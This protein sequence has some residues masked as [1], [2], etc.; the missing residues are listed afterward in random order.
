M[1]IMFH[2]STLLP[3][4]SLDPQQIHRKRRIGNDIGVV[5]FQDGGSFKP[6]ISSELIR[7]TCENLTIIIDAYFVVKPVEKKDDQKEYFRFEVVAD[8]HV[9]EFG[10]QISDPP[11]YEKGKSFRDIL[12]AKIVNGVYAS[13]KHPSLREKLW[14]R[15]KEAYLGEIIKANAGKKSYPVKSLQDF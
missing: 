14:C 11:I 15:P 3:H 6:T 1:D 9:P 2:V 4:S 5:V 10:P 13:L 7:K 8:D 12:L